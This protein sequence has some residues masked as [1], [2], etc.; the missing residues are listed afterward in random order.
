MRARSTAQRYQGF[1]SHLHVTVTAGQRDK[2]MAL[3]KREGVSLSQFVRALIDG[4]EGV[5]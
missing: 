5:K 4:L 2:L 1:D 3:A